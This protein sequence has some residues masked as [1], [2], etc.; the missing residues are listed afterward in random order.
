[1]HPLSCPK[2]PKNAPE[3]P[4]VELML[5][6]WLSGYESRETP[7]SPET[8]ERSGPSGDLGPETLMSGNPFLLGGARTR[9]S[10]AWGRSEST[11]SGS[12]RKRVS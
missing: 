12:E 3:T 4:E 2:P 6:N 8:L 5:E 9:R 10:G 11:P 1:M 7:H